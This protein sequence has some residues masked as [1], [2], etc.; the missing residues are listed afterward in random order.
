MLGIDDLRG[1]I[2]AQALG[3]PARAQHLLRLTLTQ[4]DG[5]LV[6][7]YSIVVGALS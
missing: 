2:L 6:D 4:P 3:V 7:G 5:A 1:R